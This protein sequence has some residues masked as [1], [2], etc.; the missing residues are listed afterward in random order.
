MPMPPFPA[1]PRRT[2]LLAFL[3]TAALSP[4]LPALAQQGQQVGLVAGKEAEKFSAA[5]WYNAHSA[6]AY[7]NASQVDA[8]PFSLKE[9]DAYFLMA[10]SK[11]TVKS[12]SAKRI[13]HHLKRHEFPH[14]LFAKIQSRNFG[15]IWPIQSGSN[16]VN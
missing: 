15:S 3:L 16:V 1:L 9:L 5:Q 10:L 8:I 4:S 12:L 6:T 7:L 14:P 2:A 13:R 11:D